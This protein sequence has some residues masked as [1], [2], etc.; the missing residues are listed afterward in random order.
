MAG[1]ESAGPS[2]PKRAAKRK[3]D[4]TENPSPVKKARKATT[5]RAK[6]KKTTVNVEGW[7]E[8]FQKL[9]KVFKALNTVLGFCAGRQNIATTFDTIRASV[10]G[11]LREPLDLAKVAEI[12]ALLPELV[13]FAYRPADEMRINSQPAKRAK[14]PEFGKFLDTA[15]SRVATFDESK[16]EHV[17]ILELLGGPKNKDAERPGILTAPQ[18]L[19]AR[20]VTKLIEG[21]NDA[22]VTA[23]EQL[24][25]VTADDD[26]AIAVIQTSGRDCVPVN[27][28]SRSVESFAD[29]RG[30][31][32]TEV[33]SSEERPG[34]E[35]V[36]ED[37]QE[38]LWY[39]G[40]VQYRRA[41]DAR[42]AQLGQLNTA[43]SDSI[44]H[45]L[46]SSRGVTSLYLHQAA[47]VN[48]LA[49]GKDVIVSTSTAS[50]KSII[51]QVPIIQFL[52]GD[53]AATALIIYPTKA[54]A[55]DQKQAFE[56]LLY[57]CGGLENVQVA[58][59]D[60]DTPQTERQRIRDQTSVIMT[61]FDTIHAAMLPHEDLW[62]RFLKNLK[63]VAVDEL[64][65][66][67]NVFGS[68][69]AMVMR[70]L[71]RICAA[72]GN[73]RIRF[74]SC[75]A[76]I[77]RPSVH[78]RT[79]FGLDTVE[80]VTEDGA[81]AGKKDFVIWEPPRLLEGSS[82]QHASPVAEATG[83]MRYLMKRGVRVILFCKIRKS[84]EHA[85][86]MIR[87]DLT[88]EG[89]LD[90]LDRVQAY[91][92][93]YSQED[94]RKI[95]Q[96]AFSGQLLGII[97]TNALELGVDIGV[98]DAV[99]M[100]GF[101]VTVASLRQQ[102]GRAG[103]RG[104]DAL[105]VL[106]ASQAPVDQYYLANPEE[107][108]DKPMKE[109]AVELDNAAIV[110]AH[111]QCAAFEMPMKK[112]DEKWFGPLTAEICAEK[113]VVDKDG[114]YHT[115]PK[116]L[117]YPAKDVSLRGVEEQKYAII[118]VTRLRQSGTAKII[119]ELEFS[120]AL[121]ELYEGGIFLHQGMPY[122]VQ[123]ISHD[124][125]RANVIRTNVGWVTEPRDFTNIDAVQTHRI[126]EIRHS[127]RLAFYGRVEVK[128][129][130]FGYFKVKDG[131]I[132]DN[133]F[134][135]MPPYE[136]T[137]T[138]LWIDVSKDALELMKMLGLSLAAA[139]HSAQ[140]AVLNRFLLSADLRTECKPDEKEKMKTPTTRTRP[141]RLVFYEHAS[142]GGSIAARAF[143]H[144]SDLLREAEERARTCDCY[145]GCP[146]CVDSL[147]C[148]EH[149]SVRSRAGALVVLRDILALPIDPATLPAL[150][151]ATDDP[152]AHQTIVEAPSVGRAQDVK[153][154]QASPSPA[155]SP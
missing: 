73:R 132:L 64:H 82:Q 153:I 66:Y 29:T 23:V 85:M 151:T 25:K 83:L 4:D 51:Y 60:G 14:S 18:A 133:V 87:Q 43:L 3:S 20:A 7:P 69:A 113:L 49:D 144:I 106:I 107:L 140:H 89:R 112:Q 79:I 119:E 12:K 26:E 91:R 145:D 143:D 96:E 141:A 101:P 50:G 2:K 130:V 155:A 154:E 9:F 81:P 152:D 38:E 19:N 57:A 136:R 13:V 48:A 98:L 35:E 21:R 131:R 118:D 99:L 63:L 54:L 44:R 150:E 127:P 37:I 134:V 31:E 147:G 86:K 128:T 137:T 115:H 111:M 139:I 100:L 61:N 88:S 95:E 15:A 149:N 120:R 5:G 17:L 142:T 90:I 124:T 72:L 123:E 114:W 39:N 121:F 109:L 148:K 70:R 32:P 33:P 102:I 126:R 74:V 8:Y 110:E 16:E 36:L 94:R 75:S 68:H 97:A 45:A 78:M 55:Q 76:T 11:L 65:Y 129:T 93:G 67:H 108:W 105:G 41:F 104:R 30:K 53:L 84:C 80:E 22:F 116:F 122:L 24:L 34:I 56:N 52:E 46:Q 47:A 59:Y 146:E 138:G 1:N 6:N 27:P 125:M 103:R 117:P 71:R 28:L 58:T 135:D 77:E 10:E 62:R 92:G 42:E 40:Q